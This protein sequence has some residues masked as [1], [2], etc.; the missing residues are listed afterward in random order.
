MEE[1]LKKFASVVDYGSFTAA[2]RS[3]HISQPGLTGAVQKLERE[4]KAALLDHHARRLTLTPAGQI[5][6]SQGKQL[7]ML[8]ANLEQTISELRG[9]KQ[10]FH[11]GCI[12]SLAEQLVR[13]QLLGQLELQTALSLNVQSSRV[14]LQELG[15]G[16]LD[17]AI[18]VNQPVDGA[19]LYNRRAGN[20]AFALVCA[21]SRVEVTAENIKRGKL[22]DFLAYNPQS[23][24]FGLLQNQLEQLGISPEY[25]LYSTNPSILLEL[26][27]QGRGVAA[28]PRTMLPKTD[29]RLVELKLAKPLHRPIDICWQ[30]GRI[31]PA[32]AKQLFANLSKTMK[33]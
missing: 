15:R 1:R 18:I 13:R 19:G 7:Q 14:L 6:Y 10:P 8:A 32:P 24:T 17:A 16:H 33:L 5:A 25:R 12:D 11:L 27:E 23:T 4:L 29:G 31:L 22:P 2:A 26:A 20:E 3:L 21:E 30:R 9:Q 28:L